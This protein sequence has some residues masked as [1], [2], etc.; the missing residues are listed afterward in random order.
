MVR[1][2]ITLCVA[3][4]FSLGLFSGCRSTVDWSLPQGFDYEHSMDRILIQIEPATVS[5]GFN[6]DPAIVKKLNEFLF[7][8]FS[9]SARFVVLSGTSGQLAGTQN[10]VLKITP[11]LMR[12]Q[13]P[14][15]PVYYCQTAI[16]CRL[17]D[18]ETGTFSNNGADDIR[19]AKN[20]PGVHIPE[21][22]QKSHRDM[23]WSSSLDDSFEFVWKELEKRI[24]AKYPANAKIASVQSI[25]N[26]TTFSIAAGVANGFRNDDV[27]KIYT[28]KNGIATVVAL[29]SG[30][31]GKSHST[32]TVTEWNME[33]LRVKEIYY[34]RIMNNDIRDLYVVT[35]KRRETN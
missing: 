4:I 9:S 18:L 29:A 16:T 14:R 11:I 22:Y 2:I 32:L 15:A 8:Q 35:E 26:Q 19:V 30:Q 12:K 20:S 7:H 13:H 23:V 25:G 24:A 5:R 31:I 10:K 34:P 21:F 27:F 3:V 33:D 17:F 28:V 6:V 1:K